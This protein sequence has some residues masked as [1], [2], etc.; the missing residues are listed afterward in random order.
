MVEQ[1]RYWK[2][3][4]VGFG[5]PVSWYVTIWARSWCR[6]LRALLP[7]DTDA[8][9]LQQLSTYIQAFFDETPVEHFRQQSNVQK[10]QITPNIVQC[11]QRINKTLTHINTAIHTLFAHK[12]SIETRGVDSKAMHEAWYR[13]GLEHSIHTLREH[14]VL[15]PLTSWKTI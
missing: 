12:C 2:T 4:L 6:P 15:V 3:L 9:R 8:E 7:G 10:E 14:I 5:K 1:I 13:S 11:A